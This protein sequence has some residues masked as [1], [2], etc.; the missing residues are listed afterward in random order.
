MHLLPTIIDQT[1]SN[2]SGHIKV[3]EGFGFKHLSTDSIQHSGGI[4]KE[5][6]QTVLKKYSISKNKNWLVLGVAGGSVINYISQKY[7][8]NK[9]TGI[10]IDPVIVELGK[11]HFD[12]LKNKNIE[13]KITDAY[14]YC[15]TTNNNCDYLLV[16]LFGKDSCPDFVYTTKFLKKLVQLSPHV[17]INHLYHTPKAVKASNTLANQLQ[18]SKINYATHRILKN[19]VFVIWKT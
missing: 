2:Y 4:V 6:W 13:L 15:I 16:D 18:K 19:Q 5:I 11:K 7:Q 1:Y 3:I 12:L 17:F 14:D 8:P 9:I 10:D